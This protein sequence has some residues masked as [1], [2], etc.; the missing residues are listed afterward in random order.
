VAE[1]VFRTDCWVYSAELRQSNVG[2]QYRAERVRYGNVKKVAASGD[3]PILT[4]SDA[5][6]RFVPVGKQSGD[7]TKLL[8]NCRRQVLRSSPAYAGSA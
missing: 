7:G 5:G 6:N 8:C 3:T 4:L 2:H 1:S